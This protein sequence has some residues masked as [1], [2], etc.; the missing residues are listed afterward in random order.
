[1]YVA[2]KAARHE[3]VVVDRSPTWSGISAG[4]RRQLPALPRQQRGHLGAKWFSWWSRWWSWWWW[5]AEDPGPLQWLLQVWPP[6]RAGVN[7]PSA[8]VAVPFLLL[9]G[10]GLRKHRRGSATSGSSRAFPASWKFM[11]FWISRIAPIET[12]K[13]WAFHA[14]D[15]ETLNVSI[16]TL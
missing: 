13:R 4:R 16:Q 5:Q 10:Q 6:W 15:R 2:A 8:S 9:H 7:Q 11:T 12:V 3:L 1:M 14:Q